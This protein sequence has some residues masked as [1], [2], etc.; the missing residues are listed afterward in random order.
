MVGCRCRCGGWPSGV[1]HW[2]TGEERIEQLEGYQRDLHRQ[3]AEVAE[4][5]RRLK[6][7]QQKET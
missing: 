5:L 7:G 6:E 4:E 3:A 1:A 2:P